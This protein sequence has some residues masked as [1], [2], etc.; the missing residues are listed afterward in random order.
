M[1]RKNYYSSQVQGRELLLAMPGRGNA[2]QQAAIQVA[3]K[4]AQGMGVQFT[5]TTVR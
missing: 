4:R 1:G 2:A 5:T 3:A